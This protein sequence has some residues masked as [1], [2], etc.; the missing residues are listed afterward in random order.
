MERPLTKEERLAIEIGRREDG[1]LHRV[2]A[3]GGDMAAVQ[4]VIIEE[5]LRPPRDRMFLQ[6]LF[7]SSGPLME[8]IQDAMEPEQRVAILTLFNLFMYG[9]ETYIP[10]FLETTTEDIR[11]EDDVVKRQ[12]I[13]G[14]QITAIKTILRYASGALS[15]AMKNL[16]T[17][18]LATAGNVTA[19]AA[20]GRRR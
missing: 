1:V 5:L 14:V 12:K 13:I 20:G 3:A 6:I 11:N 17:S 2:V 4:V 10:Q 18:T 7:R 15:P 9:P 16:L 8:Y 19:A